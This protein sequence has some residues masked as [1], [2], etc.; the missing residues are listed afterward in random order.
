M[1]R[2]EQQALVD[3]DQLVIT[4]SSDRDKLST[5]I[6]PEQKNIEVVSNGVD[7]DY[8]TPWNGPR[9]SDSLVFCAKLDY[10]P[11]AQAIL[12]FCE[13]ILPL[14]WKQRPQVHLAI[15]GNNPPQAVR[16]LTTDERITVTGYVPDIRPY[17]G[18][19]SVVIAP[20]VVAAG[21]QNKVLE[22]LSMGMPT[23]TTPRCSHALGTQDGVHLLVAEDPQAYT[24]AIVKLLGDLQLAQRLGKVGRQFVVEHY[25][26]ASAANILDRLYNAIVTR[27]RQQDRAADLALLV[28]EVGVYPKVSL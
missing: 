9:T 14:I 27:P 26:W 19:A 17:L 7:T 13:N 3:F 24:Q 1:R 5:L 25:S 16:E 12:H 21:M 20:L 18:S 15:V 22:A 28:Q 4:T 8:F 23:V 6:G 2:Y 10:F 11:N